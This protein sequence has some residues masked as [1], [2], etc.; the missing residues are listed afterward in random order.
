M[1]YHEIYRKLIDRARN[2]TLTG[3]V[4]RH[5]IIP[6]CLG[7]GNES[8]NLVDL[9]A[10]EHYLAHQ[11]LVKLHPESLDLIY[12][13]VRMSAGKTLT[14]MN[15]KLYGW[16]RRRAAIASST[17]FKGKKKTEEHK[18]KIGKANAGR[19]QTPEHIARRVNS[20]ALRHIP[21]EERIDAPLTRE[22]ILENMKLGWKRQDLKRQLKKDSIIITALIYSIT[23]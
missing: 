23:Q 22:Q 2:R 8:S 10:E 6:R 21:K 18:A 15:N 3:Y 1:K 16:L 17:R 11:I 7:G 14:R 19:K 13:V 5:H 20:L 4:E 12:A 9:T